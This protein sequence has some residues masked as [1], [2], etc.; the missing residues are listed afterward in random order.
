MKNMRKKARRS[1]S[2][3]I[4]SLCCLGTPSSILAADEADAFKSFCDDAWGAMTLYDD[5]N[6]PYLQKIAFTGRLHLDYAHVDGDGTRPAPLGTDDLSWDEFNVR[7]LRAGFKATLFKDFTAHVE[8]DFDVEEDP[9]YLRLTDAYVGWKHSDAFGIKVG[10][11]GMA[12]TLDGSTSSKELLTMDRNNLT[13]N[14]WFTYEYI[15]GITAGGKVGN[16]IYNTG[17]FSQGGEDKELGDFDAGTS[18]LATIGYD[19]S[20]MLDSDEAL[21][22][23]DYVYNEENP[24][25]PPLYTNRSLGQVV[26]LNFRYEKDDFG[27]RSEIAAGDGFLGQADTFGVN[28]MPYYN[29]TD[30]LQGVLR[31]TFIE[32]EGD[33]GLRMTG[34]E[35]STVG[36]G[37]GDQY[38]E[39]YAGVNYYLYGHKLKVQSGLSFISMRDEAD[40]GGAFD[41]LSW[42][43]G[44]RLA[45]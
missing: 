27:I 34:Y 9:V 31:Y 6:N 41:G 39:L 10:K 33:N 4:L 20:K 5:S 7:R 25:T 15:P 36:G 8:G 44:I 26:S 1:S 43:T 35:S 42:I 11:Q 13:N 2:V 29:F 3:T 30:K 38:Q 28:V 18:W 21:L 23:L 17:V 16:W 14:L 32:S 45:W 37:K 19:F 22:T 40:D 24:S 12:Y